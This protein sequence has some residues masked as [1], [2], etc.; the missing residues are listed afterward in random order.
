MDVM[1]RNDLGTMMEAGYILIGMQRFKEARDVM[2]GIAVMA[3]DS[4][5]PLVAIG[6][7]DFCEGKFRS[8]VATYQKALKLNPSSEYAKAYL[9]EALF[10]SG[11][12]PEAKTYLEEVAK[13][14]TNGKAGA[15]AKALL[16]AIAQGFTPST[17]AQK[18]KKAGS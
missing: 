4:D 17:A 7:V 12:V 3:P 15:F 14:D 9:G 10:F 11:K 6:S 5:I 8:A 16:E 1:S 18:K 13:A 2:E